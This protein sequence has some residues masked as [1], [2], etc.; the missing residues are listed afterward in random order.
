MAIKQ[1]ST[2]E[3]LTASATNEFLANSGLVF[4]KAQ[5]IGSGVSSVTV[6]DAFSSTYKSYLIQLTNVT[7]TLTSV[8]TFQLTGL[9]SGYYGNLIYANLLGGSPVSAGYN[10]ASTFTH[11]GGCNGVNAYLN[12]T[13]TNPFLALPTFMTSEF[14]DTNNAGRTQAYQSSSTSVTGFSLGLTAGS[15]TGGQITIYGYRNG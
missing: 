11:A 6:T 3:V 1:F 2:G 9:T 15:I 7:A 12:L 8:I 5:T 10:N 13:C 14:V 4:V